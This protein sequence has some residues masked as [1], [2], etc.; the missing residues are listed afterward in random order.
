ML[1]LLLAS[2]AFAADLIV[3][4]ANV[5]T[6]DP[7]KPYAEAFAVENG[8][9]TAVGTNAEIRGLAGPATRVIDL[10]GKTVTPGFN[11]VH[12]HP[13]A[14]FPDDSPYSTPWL[15]PDKIKNMDQLIAAL[16]KKAAGTPKGLLVSGSRYDD[17]ALGRHPNRRD[18]DKAST[19]H[20]ISISHASGHIIAVN[21][22]I[23]EASGI[24][25]ETKDPPGGSFDRDPDGTPNGVI[26]EA[27]RRL[28]KHQSSVKVPPEEEIAGLVRCFQQYAAEESPAL[29]W[30][31]A[32]P[33]PFD[34]WKPRGTPEI[35]Y[36]P[37]SCFMRPTS[38]LYRHSD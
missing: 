19:D 10:A 9:F 31:G 8:R 20:P 18:L 23:L 6:V 35:P 33:N 4:N 34:V 36:A 38:L 14:V 15:G 11:D 28:L 32:A 24:T 1:L 5:I 7:S 27:A 2:T 25:K 22:Y 3:I 13:N 17:V 26:R 29:E 21:S 12:L 16:K 30:L 37:V